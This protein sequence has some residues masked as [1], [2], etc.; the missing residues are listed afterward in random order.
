MRHIH[1]SD[2]EGNQ[3]VC[4]DTGLEPRSFARTKMSQCLIEPGFVVYPDGTH[5]VWKAKG[6]C[7]ING[8]MRVWGTP[9]AGKRLDQLLYESSTSVSTEAVRQAAL[10]AIVF[11]IRA[12]LFL[13][14]TISALNPGAAFISFTDDNPD[15]PKGSVFFSPKNLSQRCLF[16]EGLEHD[17]YNCPDLNGMEAAAF[18]AGT[19]LYNVL[20]K[21]HPFSSSINLYQDMREG[22]FLP[23][24]LA[25]P[26][27]NSNLSNLI[28]NSLFLPVAKKRPE[29]N[30]TE[31]LDSFLKILMSGEGKTASEMIPAVSSL[32]RQVS[33]DEDKK[34]TRERV[35]YLKTQ[36]VS[37][38]V[39]R[40]VTRNRVFL[41]GVSS[42]VL[43][44]LLI[45]VTTTRSHVNRPTTAGLLPE[46]VIIAYYDAFSS[47]N[48][49][50][51]EA[52]IMGADRSDIN[53]AVN[54]FAITRL[55][56]AHERTSHA[57]VIPARVWRD[58][59]GTLPAPDVFGVT[60]LGIEQ[61]GGSE[62][63]GLMVFRA[64]YL[65]WYP[66]EEHASRRSDELTLRRHRGNW[67]ITEIHRTIY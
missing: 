42:V 9:F 4:F 39:R 16:V 63:H 48:H 52:C 56:Q 35:K 28:H 64:N 36:N 47:L 22:V 13:G 66:H 50:F 53:V 62:Q 38:R 57:A 45:I 26:G 21:F 54:F 41:T 19:M 31:I 24:V 40:F 5:K 14:E 10:Q 23:P 60:D 12:K 25:S 55:R 20:M 11:W 37:V 51:M 6:V 33:L 67:R 30:G 46:S 7:E 8:Y 65:L 49:M 58:S 32:F 27:I 18:C 17:P 61:L 29:Q 2:V 43:F 1:I 44:L 34:C 59:G 3:A 15:F